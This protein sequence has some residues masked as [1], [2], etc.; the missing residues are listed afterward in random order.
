MKK[1]ILLCLFMTFLAKSQFYQDVD[2][3]DTSL[4][5]L[6]FFS[7]QRVYH[8]R[9]TNYYKIFTNQFSVNR[10]NNRFNDPATDALPMVDVNGNFKR[11]K[12]DS[13]KAKLGLQNYLLLSNFT[14]GN[15]GGKPTLLSSVGV[16]STDFNVTN[17]PLTSNGN[18]TLDLKT[19]GIT[20]GKIL[21]TT[22]NSKGIATS[23]SNPTIVSLSNT[24]R[25]LN[26]AYQI[27]TTSFS[28]IK[29]SVQIVSVLSISG[30]QSGN[31]YLEYS[32][33]GSTGWTFT[34]QIPNG[35]TGTL[36]LGITTTQTTGGQLSSAIPVG[37]YW[38]LR[39]SGTGTFTFLG[40]EQIT[41]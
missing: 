2:Y 3:T 34:G 11:V 26:Q 13:L 28:E 23:A 17:S 27:S 32:A 25:N 36:T 41:Y 33:N 38:R 22:F 35:N 19:S 37:Y 31:I 1:L 39:T 18:I 16:T 7:G 15:L 4:Y 10:L 14:W 9:D 12:V 29:V 5:A 24:D 30:G 8:I 20:A 21:S 6:G 40:G